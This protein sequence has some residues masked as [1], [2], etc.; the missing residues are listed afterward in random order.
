MTADGEDPHNEHFD[1]SSFKE[2]W[3]KYNAVLLLATSPALDHDRDWQQDVLGTYYIKPNYIGHCGHI[4]NAG[5]LV[6]ITKRNA[7]Y[8]KVLAKSYPH[9]ASRLKYRSSVFNLVFESNVA[10]TR[11][12][13]QLG[14][15]R[16]G[17]I[18]DA[19]V[20]KGESTAAIVYQGNFLDGSVATTFNG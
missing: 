20:I 17:R 19:I 18:E 5:F 13:D 4:C 14:Y 11:L 2:Y 7:G 16:A 9:F 3:F 15:K 12:W 1:Q 10:S 8:G 6:P